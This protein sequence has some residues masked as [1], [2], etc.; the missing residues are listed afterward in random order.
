M[1]S[2]S[3]SVGCETALVDGRP[4]SVVA[5]TGRAWHLHCPPDSLVGA[6]L[7]DVRTEAVCTDMGGVRK[8][9]DECVTGHLERIRD[10]AAPA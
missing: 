1:G 9:I 3:Y 5:L 4:E 2:R 10:S 7:F 6:E 8:M